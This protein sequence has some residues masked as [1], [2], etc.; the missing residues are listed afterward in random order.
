MTLLND[1]D[2]GGGNSFHTLIKIS[3]INVLFTLIKEEEKLFSLVIIG[4]FRVSCISLLMLN[5]NSQ[6]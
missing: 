1:A 5:V 3:C 6:N 2:G 4:V